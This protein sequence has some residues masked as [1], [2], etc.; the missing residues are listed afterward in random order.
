[1]VTCSTPEEA[2]IDA[3]SIYKHQVFRCAK[4]AQLH[5]YLRTALIEHEVRPVPR[6]EVDSALY[7]AGTGRVKVMVLRYGPEVEIRPRPFDGFSLVQVPLRGT[8]EIECDGQ[9]VQ[10]AAGQSALVSPRRHLRLV[11]SRDC[12]QLILRVPDTLLSAALQERECSGGELRRCQDVFAPITM[13]AG[14]SSESWKSL[15]QALIDLSA[16]RLGGMDGH[17]PSWVEHIELSMA[18][19]LLTFQQDTFGARAVVE[20][21]PR[22][23]ERAVSANRRDPLVAAERYM[24]SRLYAPIALRDLAR[25]AGVSARTL[26]VHCKRRYG[27][28]PMEWLRNL[29]LDIARERLQQSRSVQVT[30]VAMSCG[31]GHL[32]RFAEYYRERFGELPRETTVA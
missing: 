29:R 1:M 12:E 13:I 14:G 10:L 2:A 9:L 21:G 5:A 22:R 23:E 15:L 6:G 28:G 3:S 32:G 31:F 7:L 17:Y 8:M 19:F 24:R 20:C 27:V 25:A 26:H 30:N 11:W 18:S 16:L 4:L